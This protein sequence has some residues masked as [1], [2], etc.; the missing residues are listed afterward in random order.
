MTFGKPEVKKEVVAGGV[1]TMSELLKRRLEI[2]DMLDQVID[3]LG[4]QYGL[5]VEVQTAI[6]Q[7][8]YATGACPGNAP[9]WI[10]E[11]TSAEIL[12]NRLAMELAEHSSG[13]GNETVLGRVTSRETL[14]SVF[15][16]HHVG[17]AE[18]ADAPRLPS[19]TT[20]QY[21]KRTGAVV[22]PVRS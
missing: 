6:G 13:G 4:V 15:A 19:E 9:A 22:K 8:L 14:A 16:K 1:T 10:G 17:L 5:L 18:R 3:E 20:E 7:V 11:L 21:Y 2:G 12:R